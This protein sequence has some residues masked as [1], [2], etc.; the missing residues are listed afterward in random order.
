[1]TLNC[2]L[3]CNWA[4]DAEAGPGKAGIAISKFA[5][6]GFAMKPTVPGESSI[7]A[8]VLRIGSNKGAESRWPRSRT[9]APTN[10][11]MACVPPGKTAD[12]GFQ[13][14]IGSVLLGIRLPQERCHAAGVAA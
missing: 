10:A 2:P 12:A 11:L 3:R 5:P 4:S 7:V 8:W 13:V 14:G 9:R 1:M 6:L